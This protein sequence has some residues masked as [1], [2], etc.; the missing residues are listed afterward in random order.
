LPLQ[1]AHPL[2]TTAMTTAQATA[3]CL[4]WGSLDL[5]VAHPLQT[6]AMT[7]AE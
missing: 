3:E 4:P 1:A 6:A 5:E 7:T 2:Q